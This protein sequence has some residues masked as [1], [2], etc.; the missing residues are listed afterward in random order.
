MMME[1]PNDAQI[2]SADLTIDAPNPLD[3]SARDGTTKSNSP[4]P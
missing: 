1:S 2:N 3:K 4:T